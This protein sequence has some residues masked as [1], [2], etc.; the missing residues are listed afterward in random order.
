MD[1]F[2]TLLSLLDYFDYMRIVGVLIVVV[3]IKRDSPLMKVNWEALTKFFVFMMVISAA[4]L[5][6]MDYGHAIAPSGLSA[7][8][9]RD[10]IWVFW[11]DAFFSMP[12]Y[13]LKDHLQLRKLLWIPAAVLLSIAFYWG[14]RYYGLLGLVTLAV[15]Y[16]VS[17]KFAKKYGYG[18]VMVGHVLYDFIGI[19]T[20]NLFTMTKFMV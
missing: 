14:H 15:P 4:R 2:L 11:E 7:I 1:K 10:F 6:V 16:F 20:I 17:Y 18:T 12:I 3:M 13:F 8:G 9:Y 5:A 19:M